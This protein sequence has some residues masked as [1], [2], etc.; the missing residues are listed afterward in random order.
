[1]TTTNASEI[2]DLHRY[3]HVN[4]DSSVLWL[5]KAQ[6]GKVSMEDIQDALAEF[7]KLFKAGMA[8]KAE[9]LTLARAFPDS[10]PYTQAAQKQSEKEDNDPIV[11]GGPASVSLVDREGHLITT[12]ALQR[13]FKK[14]MKNDRTRN[15]M[16]LHSDVQVGWALPAYISKGGQ[17]FK[18][19]VNDNGLFF[20]CE[21]RD[22]T[23][24]AQKVAEQIKKGMLKSYSIA[25]SATKMQNMTKGLTPYIQVDDME[26]AEVTVCEKGVNQGASFE[27]LKSEPSPHQAFGIKVVP[28]QDPKKPYQVK[29]RP[30]DKEAML[31]QSNDDGTINFSKSFSTWMQKEKDPLTTG[32]SFV[33][34]NNE[35]GR[36]AEHEQ[37]LREYG[38]P[39]EQSFETM[40]YVPVVETETDDDGIPVHNLPPWVVNEAGEALGDRLDEDS[41]GYNKSAKA[42]ARQKAG[43]AQKMFMDFME[44][45]MP[46]G[47]PQLPGGKKN[48][49]LNPKGSRGRSRK[50]AASTTIRPY[51]QPKVEPKPVVVDEEEV[52]ERAIL[53]MFYDFMD[54]EKADRPPL[55]RRLG[56]LYRRFT[57][58]PAT[59]V[60]KSKL[61]QK[62]LADQAARNEAIRNRQGSAIGDDDT[63][64]EDKFTTSLGGQADRDK[65]RLNRVASR[66]SRGKPSATNYSPTTGQP[67]TTDTEEMAN[68]RQ[69][70]GGGRTGPAAPTTHPQRD[71][72]TGGGYPQRLLDMVSRRKN[73]PEGGLTK[74]PTGRNLGTKEMQALSDRKA[75]EYKRN[76]GPQTSTPIGSEGSQQEKV[77]EQ[78][79]AY[80][81]EQAQKEKGP[82]RL[83]RVKAG[84][85]GKTRGAWDK[86]KNI[87]SK[88]GTTV[89]ADK[90]D[91][92]SKRQVRDAKPE[93]PPEAE[94]PPEDTGPGEA[95]P[96]STEAPPTPGPRA[97]RSLRRRT[98]AVRAGDDQ[99]PTEDTGSSAVDRLSEATKQ[100]GRGFMGFRGRREDRESAYRGQQEQAAQAQAQY[101]GFA[102]RHKHLGFNE[103]ED[104]HEGGRFAQNPG[105]F[106]MAHHEQRADTRA[107]L[108]SGEDMSFEDH[109]KHFSHL[110]GSYPVDDKNGKAG[111]MMA[112]VSV[113]LPEGVHHGTKMSR[114]E[115]EQHYNNGHIKVH[116]MPA[117]SHMNVDAHAANT[118]ARYG[119]RNDIPSHIK[120]PEAATATGGEAAATTTTPDAGGSALNQLAARLQ[121]GGGGSLPGEQPQ[122]VVQPTFG[123]KFKPKGATV[124][125]G[126][127]TPQLALLLMLR[128][129]MGIQTRRTRPYANR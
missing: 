42:K 54:I 64:D 125:P 116:G 1:M 58:D 67:P 20:I 120:A 12:G 72:T 128:K 21:L 98:E 92:W 48:Y 5:E 13:A 87:Y 29:L 110:V 102:D 118:I 9:T 95:P 81:D 96:T 52:K 23:A 19:G 103:S 94:T 18:S 97:R 90:L 40:R 63:V 24:I 126:G 14:F 129:A 117:F 93:T 41:P 109:V 2:A 60:P 28:K 59:G 104:G 77:R 71:P 75:A 6:S 86:L 79:Q 31:M 70:Q 26:L 22:D 37:L 84:A 8:S 78:R 101:Q 39:S 30:K 68:I 85:A 16:V 99:A 106:G 100:R 105:H 44:K 51:M 38:F 66:R 10:V 55:R 3:Q 119:Q 11:I 108:M 62:Q 57:E 91:E 114:Q 4:D 124:G 82:S 49:A 43:S 112:R 83:S 121:G 74:P 47:K 45:D 56:E 53:N 89:A 36:R 69:R 73:V 7:S 61:N 88:T 25:G 107:A 17:I 111:A 123:S 50:G 113:H 115:F 33:T 127:V 34:L 65:A 76:Q 46:K 27:I 80:R 122:G 32:E 35:A 15:V